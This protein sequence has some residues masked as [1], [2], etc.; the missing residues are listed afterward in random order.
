[1]KNSTINALPIKSDLTLIYVS[2][3]IAAFLMAVVSISG[4]LIRNQVYPTDDIAYSFVPNDVVNLFIGLPILIGSMWSTSRGKLVGLLFWPGA[5]F[6]VLYNSIAYI[7]ALPLGWSFL[8]HLTLVMLVLYSLIALVANIDGLY[9]QQKIG[10][11]VA[12]KTGGGILAVLGGLFFLR[13]ISV[14]VSGFT[15]GES[16]PITELSVNVADFITAPAWIIGGIQLWSRKKL[17]YVAGLGLLFQASMLFVALIIYLLIQPIL[18]TVP[19]SIIDV[20]VV[21]VMGLLCFIP[22]AL[23]VRGTVL[24]KDG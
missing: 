16:I 7:V 23:F 22:F 8:G 12:E 1:M 14:I 13:A 18:T 21:F 24:G 20:I 4:I 3:A 6:Y 19:F 15:S 9:I 11:V 2:S 17:G 10:G 5:L